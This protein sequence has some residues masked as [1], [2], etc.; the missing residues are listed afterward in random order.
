MKFLLPQE[1]R[2]RW[3]P[4]YQGIGGARGDRRASVL[5]R[6]GQEQSQ[7]KAKARV[8]SQQNPQT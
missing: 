2:V 7:L 6:L 5:P 8:S 3:G 4:R 1:T